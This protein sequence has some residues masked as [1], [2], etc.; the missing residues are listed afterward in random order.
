M[1][2]KKGHLL[3]KEFKKKVNSW[4]ANPLSPPLL[5]AAS[6]AENDYQEWRIRNRKKVT[7]EIEG[8]HF[9]VFRKYEEIMKKIGLQ[10]Y[11]QIRTSESLKSGHMAT[12]TIR[13]YKQELNEL[14]KEIT[15]KRIDFSTISEILGHKHE[16]YFVCKKMEELGLETKHLKNKIESPNKLFQ[17]LIKKMGKENYLNTV[18]TILKNNIHSYSYSLKHKMHEEPHEFEFDLNARDTIEAMLQ[19]LEGKRKISN[20]TKRKLAQTDKKFRKEIKQLSKKFHIINEQHYPKPF[21]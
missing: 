2:S 10:K 18:E 11:N 17:N 3:V 13:L 12:E 19:E 4:K 9:Q 16:F 20:Y 21:W 6:N 1:N 8:E 14:E 7:K 15:K 5:L